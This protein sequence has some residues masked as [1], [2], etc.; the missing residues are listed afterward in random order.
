[1]INQSSYVTVTQI[2]RLSVYHLSSHD[3]LVII[4][5][6]LSFAEVSQRVTWGGGG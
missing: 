6:H 4:S 1:M 3:Y 2:E 5:K